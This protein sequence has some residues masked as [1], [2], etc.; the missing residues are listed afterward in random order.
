MSRFNQIRKIL[1]KTML[2]AGVASG[3]AALVLVVQF[4]R[5]LS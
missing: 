3:L 5:V 1:R 2:V 4:A